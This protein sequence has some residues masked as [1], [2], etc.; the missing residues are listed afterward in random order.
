MENTHKHNKNATLTPSNVK[1]CVPEINAKVSMFDYSI[2]TGKRK[3]RKKRIPLFAL[4]QV[5]ITEGVEKTIPTEEINVALSRHICG[6]WGEVSEL[7]F[8]I[9]NC[10]LQNEQANDYSLRHDTMIISQY[11]S[12]V[13]EDVS[14]WIITNDARTGTTILLPDELH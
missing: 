9:N 2:D 6:D 4:G 3:G 12:K 1:G 5:T 11:D 14:F 7:E 13:Q 10:R 8:E